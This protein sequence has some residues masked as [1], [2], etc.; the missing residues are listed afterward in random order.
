MKNPGNFLGH[1]SPDWKKVSREFAGENKKRRSLVLGW[2]IKVYNYMGI[3]WENG[4]TFIQRFMGISWE[5]HGK[6]LNFQGRNHTHPCY[7]TN[8]YSLQVYQC[9]QPDTRG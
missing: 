3:T 8:N 4:G 2:E 6:T 9:D 7:G 5:F 1:F